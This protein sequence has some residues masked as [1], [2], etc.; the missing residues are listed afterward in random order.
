LN[1]LV[2]AQLSKD[3][4][5]TFQHI[6][7]TLNGA[8]RV[9]Y[10]MLQSILAQRLDQAP[11]QQGQRLLTD[12]EN[13]RGADAFNLLG[14]NNLTHI[15]DRPKCNRLETRRIKTGRDGTGF[16]GSSGHAQDPTL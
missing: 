16:S 3:S 2:Y 14:H 10:K 15:K 13:I 12:H 1:H 8:A 4:S 9:Y 6:T 5:I 7:D 11:L